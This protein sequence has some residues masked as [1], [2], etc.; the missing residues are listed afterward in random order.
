MAYNKM[1]KWMF[2]LLYVSYS[3][4]IYSMDDELGNP[5]GS[6]LRN[7]YTLLGRDWASRYCPSW[8]HCPSWL[9]SD[10]TTNGIPIIAPTQPSSMAMVSSKYS[11]KQ[12]AMIAGLAIGTG[13]VGYI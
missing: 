6:D 8:L 1:A 13:V 2:V 12:I 10:R 9:R 3:I 5:A 4:P 7:S 11:R